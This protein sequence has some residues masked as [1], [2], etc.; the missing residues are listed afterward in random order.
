MSSPEQDQPTEE[1]NLYRK[2]ALEKRGTDQLDRLFQSSHS[3]SWVA[4]VV[5]TGL[6]CIAIAW[7]FLGSIPLVVKGQGIF[8]NKEGLFSIQSKVA[9]T[10]AKILVRPGEL[11]E[12]GQIVALIDDS[13]QKFKYESAVIKETQMKQ[14][15]EKLRAQVALEATA[16]KEALEKQIK[17]SITTIKELENSITPLEQSLK[18]KEELLKQNLLSLN[19]VQETRQLLT[20]RKIALEAAKGNLED[21][22]ATQAKSYRAAE[23][24]NKEND[25]LQAAQERELLELSQHLNSVYSSDTGA[26]TEILVEVGS[27]VNAGAPLMH[28]EY[29]GATALEQ[30]VYAYVP[31]EIGKKIQIGTTVEIE[32]ST[33]NAQEYGAI[34]GHV[35]EISAFSVSAENIANLIQNSSLVEFLTKGKMAAI[36]LTIVPIQ[37]SQTFS[38]LKWTSGLGPKTKISTGTVCSVK[39]IVERESP[40]FYFFTISK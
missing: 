28:L 25:L 33:V 31:V 21:F 24:K 13:R 8:M 23:I 6:L 1:D 27:Y 19:D 37:D 15:L 4:W 36:Q 5:V 20:Q 32:P 38:G 9:G 3:V 40:L 26:I 30:I 12:K 2:K 7:L 35:T 29:A 10:V 16:Q 22:K 17:S 18:K 34:I 11:V 14:S 39:A